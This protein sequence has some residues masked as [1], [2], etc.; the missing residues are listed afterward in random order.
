MK[1]IGALLGLQLLLLPCVLASWWWP[2]GGTSSSTDAATEGGR[3]A[4]FEGSKKDKSTP[5]VIN[6]DSFGDFGSFWGIT[7]TKFDG[8]L[9]TVSG[10]RRSLKS[11]RGK[12]VLVVNVDTGD[13]AA[14]AEQFESLKTLNGHSRDK[15]EVLAL[16]SDEFSTTKHETKEAFRST[17]K[18]LMPAAWK[19]TFIISDQIKTNGPRQHDIYRFLKPQCGAEDVEA[20]FEKFLTTRQGRTHRRYSASVAFDKIA[21]D[22][23]AIV[24]REEL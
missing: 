7:G 1:I 17:L 2:F 8:V 19:P 6:C 22:V 12:A 16:L 4:N 3:Y 18:G 10:K 14:A 23:A 21:E 13:A 11:Y 9:A 5:G 15:F 20:G 24:D